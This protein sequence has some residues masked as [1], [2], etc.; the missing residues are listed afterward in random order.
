MRSSKRAS[1]AA[2]H[3]KWWVTPLRDDGP[4]REA[5]DH[6]R[7]QSIRPE[8]AEFRHGLV[9]SVKGQLHE[10]IAIHQ[11][12]P[13]AGQR[14]QDGIQALG[15][16]PV[17][18]RPGIALVNVHWVVPREG[19][20]LGILLIGPVHHEVKPRHPEPA[21]MLEPGPE[22]VAVAIDVAEQR[23]VHRA[24]SDREGVK[25]VSCRCT[26]RAFALGSAPLYLRPATLEACAGTDRGA[27]MDDQ[28]M[29]VP[30][31]HRGAARGGGDR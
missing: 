26:P 25:A 28:R 29:C 21:V 30:P 18:E 15:L 9:D 2:R 7:G 24:G 27:G 13:A 4:S 19:E 20:E 6:G 12:H 8:P 16:L 23:Q 3:L 17:P 10:L 22:D 11:Q 5:L 1:T 14:R 31:V